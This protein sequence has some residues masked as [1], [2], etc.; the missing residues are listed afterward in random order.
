MFLD[1]LLPTVFGVLGAPKAFLSRLR[2]P[3]MV[4]YGLLASLSVM[5]KKGVIRDIDSIWDVGAN[6]GQFAFMAHTVWRN[7][8][9]YSFEPDDKVFS[10]LEDNFKKFDILG[11]C[12]PYALG[13]ELGSKALYHCEDTVN[14]SLLEPEERESGLVVKQSQIECRTLDS[15]L[16]EVKKSQS[17]LLKLDV[18]GYEAH[19]LRGGSEF[20]SH[21]KYVIAEATFSSQYKGGVHA[22]EL[23]SMMRARGFIC[24]Q[25][26]DI[27]RDKNSN[28]G[29]IL[30]IDILFENK[31]R[32][33]IL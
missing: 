6:V 21:C 8:P 19:V 18:Q 32:S 12:F 16:A 25:I 22:D 33:K 3:R 28:R 9:V 23:I 30:E 17:P 27:L 4:S 31:Q 24:I 2:N 7:L 10:Q 20:L 14:T 5:K 1:N 15:M 26:M 29:E 13:E 11:S